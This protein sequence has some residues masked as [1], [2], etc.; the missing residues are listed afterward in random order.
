MDE[1]PHSGVAVALGSNEFV[2]MLTITLRG[3]PIPVEPWVVADR[4]VMALAGRGR[5][6]RW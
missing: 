4:A 6:G 1:K 5:M 3:E 2:P